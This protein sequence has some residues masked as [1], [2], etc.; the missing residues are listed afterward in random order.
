MGSGYVEKI[1]SPS[2][3][4]REPL[5]K[6]ELASQKLDAFELYEEEKNFTQRFLKTH[7][8]KL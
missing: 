4:F 5:N 7:R 6:P 8:S 1:Q 3:L 2:F